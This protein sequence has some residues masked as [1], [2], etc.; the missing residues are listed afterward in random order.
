[1]GAWDSVC[2]NGRTA[3]T[4]PNRGYPPHILRCPQP[5]IPHLHPLEMGTRGTP[6]SAWGPW[7]AISAAGGR[8]R[9]EPPERAPPRALASKAPPSHAG[10]ARPTCFPAARTWPAA[11]A[12][13]PCHAGLASRAQRSVPRRR[14]AQPG[15]QR[16]QNW[17]PGSLHTKSAAVHQGGAQLGQSCPAWG[18]HPYL[19]RG[20]PAP[21][22]RWSPV[23][24][25]PMGVA[26]VPAPHWVLPIW[27]RG[28]CPQGAHVSGD[29]QV[30]SL[31]RGAAERGHPKGEMAISGTAGQ[32]EARPVR[33]LAP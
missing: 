29:E 18:V 10:S 15:R 21:T 4:P 31:W 33:G 22:P 14:V 32:Q 24:H 20:S 11:A 13:W 9:P 23:A 1:M 19:G 3:A 5:P 26:W 12:R 17:W 27:S 28:L 30:P 7:D 8:S 6:V 16:C 2:A 25:T